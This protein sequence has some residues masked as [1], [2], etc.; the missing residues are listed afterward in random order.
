MLE[1]LWVMFGNLFQSPLWM[2]FASHRLLNKCKIPAFMH[3]V[4][5]A[6]HIELWM[7][8]VLME[9]QLASAYTTDTE[10]NGWPGH[11]IFIPVAHVT[12]K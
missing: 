7:T 9:L 12:M 11:N 5:S 1:N 8:V 10:F 2:A 3:M 6:E 4:H